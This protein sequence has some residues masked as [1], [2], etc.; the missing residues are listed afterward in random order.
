MFGNN[1]FIQTAKIALS[2]AVVM[3]LSGCYLKFG[4]NRKQPAAQ[5]P[6]IINNT[7]PTPAAHPQPAQSSEHS[8]TPIN[9]K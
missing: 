9:Q 4:T 5:Q 6:V 8:L 3:S 2:I 1:K 7:Q